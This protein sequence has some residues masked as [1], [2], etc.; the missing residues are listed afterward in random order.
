MGQLAAALVRPVAAQRARHEGEGRSVRPLDLAHPRV[1]VVR[2]LAAVPQPQ[3]V[4]DVLAHRHRPV[5]LELGYLVGAVLR[6]VRPSDRLEGV[7]PAAG[8]RVVGFVALRAA[9]K[10]LIEES[11]GDLLKIAKAMGKRHRYNRQPQ[12]TDEEVILP[13]H[14]TVEEAKRHQ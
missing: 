5:K 10:E 9:T 2:A 13:S 1:A 3:R 6:Q 11:C 7:P 14:K 12:P 8:G 4:L